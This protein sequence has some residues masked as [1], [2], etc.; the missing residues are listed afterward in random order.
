MGYRAKDVLKT[1]GQYNIKV[2]G[3]CGMFGLDNDMSSNS[4]AVR[5]NAIDYIRRQLDFSEEV[6]ASYMLAVPGAVGRPKAYDDSEFERSVETLQIVANDFS[7][8]KIRAAIE[9]IRSVEVSLIHTIAGTK[10]TLQ[11]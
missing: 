2:A 11:R 5:Q 7:N 9:P 4:G 6:G 10:N 3:I 8:A 1:L